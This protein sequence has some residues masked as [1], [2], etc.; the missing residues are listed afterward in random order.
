MPKPKMIPAPPKPAVPKVDANAAEMARRAANR[1]KAA[2]KG[3][4]AE[5]AHKAEMARRALNRRK[6]GGY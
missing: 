6:A 4:Q 3:K 1:A 2:D 5:E